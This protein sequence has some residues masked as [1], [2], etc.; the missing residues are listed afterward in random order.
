[1]LKFG[2][3]LAKRSIFYLFKP[4]CDLEKGEG[5]QMKST[6]KQYIYASLEKIHQMVQKVSCKRYLWKW[7]QVHQKLNIS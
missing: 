2:A 4:S 7:G 6:P 5:H 1:M 3:N